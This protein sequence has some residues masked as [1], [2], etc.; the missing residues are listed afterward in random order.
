MNTKN[1]I[2]AISKVYA[3]ED[4]LEDVKGKVVK[5][6][7]LYALMDEFNEEI[8]CAITKGDNEL[9]VLI[10]I[11]EKLESGLS[12][13]QRVNSLCI[14]LAYYFNEYVMVGDAYLLEEDVLTLAV[15]D[16]Y[17]KVVL[18]KAV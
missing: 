15:E 13:K 8:E 18:N 1:K 7:A 14:I 10:A 5:V 12:I 6:S 4:G 16:L 2:K 17:K 9:L 3:R 11:W